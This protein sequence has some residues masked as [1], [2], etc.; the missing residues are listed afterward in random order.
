MYVTINNVINCNKLLDICNDI[1]IT[2]MFEEINNFIYLVTKLC[3]I[4]DK[5]QKN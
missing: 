5:Y 2:S 1:C 4:N 3:D